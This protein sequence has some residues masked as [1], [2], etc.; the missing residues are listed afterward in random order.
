MGAIQPFNATGSF[1]RLG[2]RGRVVVAFALDQPKPLRWRAGI[3]QAFI[4]VRLIC[5]ARGHPARRA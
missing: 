1:A 4:F 2:A 5:P 3:H